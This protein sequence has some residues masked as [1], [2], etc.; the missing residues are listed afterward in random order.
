MLG[1]VSLGP[2]S[3]E[4]GIHALLYLAIGAPRPLHF[5]FALG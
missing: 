4:K 1:G 2:Q 5:F 3:I